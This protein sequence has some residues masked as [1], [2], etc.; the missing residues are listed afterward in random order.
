MSDQ[1]IN[2][3]DFNALA[4]DLSGQGDGIAAMPV[5]EARLATMLDGYASDERLGRFPN[6]HEVTIADVAH[7]AALAGCRPEYMPVLVAAFSI[8]LAPSF[9][10]ALFTASRASFYP[11]LIISGPIRNQIGLNCRMSVFGP[12][13]RANST[14][15]RALRLGLVHLA[16][17]PTGKDDPST[18]GTPYRYTCVIGEDEENSPWEPFHTS[19]GLS[20]TESA[21]TVL[22]ALHPGHVTQQCSVNP[23]EILLTYADELTVGSC[24]QGADVALPEGGWSPKGVVVIGDD[25]RGFF[26][27]AGWGRQQMKQFLHK[28]TRRRA[29]TLRAA[30]F[31]SDPR[32][33]AARDDDLI[34]AY[35]DAEDII[36]VAAGSGGGRAM[37]T[38]AFFGETRRIVERVSASVFPAA[39]GTPSTIDDFAALVDKYMDQGMTDGWPVIL[40]DAP[41]VSNLIAATGRNGSEIIGHAPWRPQPITVQDIAINA[42]MAG[43]LPEQMPL[44]LSMMELLFS[45]EADTGVGASACSTHGYTCWFVVQGPVGREIGINSGNALF[46]PGRQPSVAIGRTARLA[47]MNLA[48]LKPNLADRACLGQAAKYGAIIAEDADTPWGPANLGQELAPG[49]SGFTLFWG[50]HA[51]ATINNEVHDPETLLKGIAENV[52]TIQTFD[53]L[54]ARAPGETKMAEGTAVMA[55]ILLNRSIAVFISKGHQNILQESGW[56][57]QDVQKYL[58]EKAGRTARDIRKMGFGTSPFVEHDQDDDDFIRPYPPERIMLITAGGE[59]GATMTWPILFYNTRKYD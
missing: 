37:V 11:Y 18:L 3:A 31:A 38:P 1:A 13:F 49:Q 23:E 22:A 8:M 53:S 20:E 34:H 51:R 45:P 7:V 25:H 57:R 36:V 39:S 42:C 14:I 12:G 10:I 2:V 35:R 40:P 58:S 30:G 32:I 59:G 44:C 52:A 19:I 46:G 9:P 6:G 16:G 17:A 28:A 33:A 5:T 43:V 24:F 47:M 50:Q 41:I 4:L 55:G 15:G 29:G 56:S 48:G 21:V 26:S 27:T 54:S